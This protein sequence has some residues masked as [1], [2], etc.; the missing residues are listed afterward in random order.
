MEQ[1]GLS[2]VQVSHIYALT[3]GRG[4]LANA[5]AGS[6]LYVVSL[7]LYYMYIK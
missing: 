1:W 4:V 7:F 3:A 5:F 2:D 6:Y